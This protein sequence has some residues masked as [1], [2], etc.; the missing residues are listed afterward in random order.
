VIDG[1]AASQVGIKEGDILLKINSQDVEARSQQSIEQLRGASYPLK[2]NLL[3]GAL[4][5][6]CVGEDGIIS[7]GCFMCSFAIYE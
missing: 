4:V 2:L 3:R 6:A 1:T 5:E 7:G